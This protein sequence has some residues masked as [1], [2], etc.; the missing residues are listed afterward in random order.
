[1]S[2]KLK[3]GSVMLALAAAAT[4]AACSD[5]LTVPNY[6]SPTVGSISS[7][8][9]A[10]IPLLATGVLRDDRGALAT[11]V[12]DVGILGREIYNYMPTEGR[13]TSGYLT[14]DVNNPTSFGATSSGG[15]SGQY[16][17]VRDAFNT[18]TVLENSG[19][20]FTDA[21]KNAV[22]GIMHTQ[23]ALAILYVVN[24][25]DSLGAPVE[26]SAGAGQLF[27]FVSRDSVFKFISGTLDAAAAEL[28]AAGST[29][30]PF[31]MPSGYAGFNTPATYL[32]FN[33]A[34][35]ARV[36]AYRASLGTEG[37]A[38]A[39]SA[40]CYNQAL[41][42]LTS[43]FL[44]PTGSMT[45]GVF[46]VYSA[47]SG[48]VANGLSNE[49]TTNIVAHAK[50]DSGIL[51]KPDNTPDNRFLA[52]FIQ[53]SSPKAP[54]A[55]VDAV[56]TNWDYKLYDKRTDP[57]AVIRNE[58]LILLRAEARYY[59]GDVNGAL[60]DIN[61]VRTV[62]GGLAARGAFTD[63][64]DFLNELLYN[65]RLSLSFEGHRWIDMRRF[66]RLNLLTIDRPSHIVVAK[67]PVPQNECLARANAPAELKG[68][69]C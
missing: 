18:L 34:L 19:N 38:P 57:I 55:T 22:R 15:F 68:P 47:A 1:M 9:I 4:L 48:D 63:E 23:V 52:K 14:S 59:T 41:T 13:N 65:R 61:T 66:N 12:R 50:S 44:N 3:S 45:L 10:A 16:F 28:T 39:R 67:L 6:Q 62:S 33:R 35:A 7:D 8:P 51:V 56:P 2:R 31:K 21:Q 60:E 58:E 49:A 25:R 27:P 5:R 11:Y 42:A 69:G 40:T 17:T 43:S 54:P 46:D 20:V 53:L 32:K 29:A 24:T 30:F 26:V 36:L 37:C 64:A